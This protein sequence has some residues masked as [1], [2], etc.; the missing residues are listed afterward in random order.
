M[1]TLKP[2]ITETRKKKILQ[3]IIYQ[4]I[5]TGKPVSSDNITKNYHLN[6]SPASIRKIMSDLEKEGFLTHPHTSSGRVPSDKGYR[7]FVDSLSDLQK[8]AVTEKRKILDEFRQHMGEMD[9][10][11]LKTSQLLSLVSNYTGFVVAPKMDRNKIKT[12]ELVK[13]SEDK[14]M[15]LIVTDSGFVKHYILNTGPVVDERMLRY[16]SEIFNEKYSG[17]ALSEFKGKIYE[18]KD[19]LEKRLKVSEDFMKAFSKNL[20]SDENEH[21]YIEGT[22]NILPALDKKNYDYLSSLIKVLEQ[23][24]MLINML[25]KDI[26]KI[27]GVEVTIGKENKLPALNELSFIKTV[28]KVGDSPLGVLGIIGPKRMEYSKMISIVNLIGEMTNQL[29]NKYSK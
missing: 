25:E 24:K 23:K 10:V 28:Y 27:K 12:L 22:S 15:V 3:T 13:I 19:E 18:I 17:V 5:T 14:V 26:E 7:W 4:Y 16:I 20:L 2:E 1:R 8:L 6:L 29:L 9:E 11:F 21:L